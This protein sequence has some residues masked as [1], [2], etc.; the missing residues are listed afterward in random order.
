MLTIKKKDFLK[1]RENGIAMVKGNIFIY[2]TD[3]IYGIGCNA[4]NGELVRKIR[5]IKG[6]PRS[7]FSV[8]APSKRWIMEN[9]ECREEWLDVL[10]GPYTLILKLK[11]KECIASDT[12]GS[13]TIASD[14][15]TVG[16]RIPDHWFAKIAEDLNLP[17]ITTSVNGSGEPPMT[18]IDEIP[19]SIKKH[20]HFA[21]D[22]GTLDNE[23]STIVDCTGDEPRTVE[24]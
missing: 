8:I 16:V 20:V 18:C 13:D 4:Q 17:I 5:E 3:T 6:R 11:N 12:I 14:I 9:T 24:R 21:I 23:P 1:L 19:E 15:V 7:P 22:E 2:P 10:P